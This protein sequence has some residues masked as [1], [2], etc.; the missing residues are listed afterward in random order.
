M[1]ISQ[2]DDKAVP[3]ALS[4][5]ERLEK[6]EMDKEAASHGLEMLH[7]F[8]I[9][10]ASY[11]TFG[12][13]AQIQLPGKWEITRHWDNMYQAIAISSRYKF[14]AQGETPR[15]AFDAARFEMRAFLKEIKEHLENV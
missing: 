2:D 14:A 7:S 9:G 3:G 13:L 12:G 6:E 15:K 5:A 11:V 10:W 1:S 4:Q 8:G